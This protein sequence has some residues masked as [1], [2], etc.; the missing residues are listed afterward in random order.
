MAQ[1]GV[2]GE[3]KLFGFEQMKFTQNAN[4]SVVSKVIGQL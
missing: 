4:D 2:Y 1:E 3:W